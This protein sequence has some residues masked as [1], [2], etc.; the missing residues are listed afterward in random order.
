M[1]DQP[2]DFL[3]ES[4]ALYRLLAP[5]PD[6]EFDRPTRFKQ[7]TI[8][9][10]LGHLH[11]GNWAAWQTVV[12]EP[13]YLAFR[14]ERKAKVPP[15]SMREFEKQFAQ[16]LQG[17]ALLEAWHTLCPQ[18]AGTFEQTD[19]KR[20]LKWVGP[21]MSARSSITARL[22]ETWAHGQA[23]YDL[24]G[25]ERVD[26]DRIRNIVVLGVNTF[27]WTYTVHGLPVPPVMPEVRLTSPSGQTWRHGEPSQTDF[28][29]GS[30]T[31]FCQVVAQVRHVADT[32]LRV[33]G[34]TATHWMSI[35][36]CFAGPPETPPAPGTRFRET[37][38]N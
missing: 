6:A 15:M 29:E 3:A 28:V 27:G 8:N 33:V 18:V 38:A 34:P 11:L 22:M 9:H 12:D 1:F 35:A 26:G 23:V 13:R 32:R 2:A 31:E 4:E 24:L 17:R 30:A 21:D 36:Q 5:L 7:W 37:R 16:G 10:V 14:E 25:V 20:R 19:P